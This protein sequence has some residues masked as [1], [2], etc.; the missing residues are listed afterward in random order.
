MKTKETLL[1]FVSKTLILTAPDVVY[2]SF[3]FFIVAIVVIAF[4]CLFTFI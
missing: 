4:S 2:S 1:S 3:L